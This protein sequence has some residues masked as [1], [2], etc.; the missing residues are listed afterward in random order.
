MLTEL[1]KRFVIELA[2]IYDKKEA[3][4]L[5]YTLLSYLKK[6]SV[7]A[8]MAEREIRFE[9]EE[10]ETFNKWIFRLKQGEPYQYILGETE[11]L[12]RLFTVNSHVLIPRPET[13]E[14][15]LWII[16]E[17][18]QLPSV[19]I[20]DIGTGSGCLAISLALEMPFARVYAMDISESALQVAK[21][22]AERLKAN[23]SFFKGDI[24][25]PVE[26]FPD[27]PWDVI[28]SNPPYIPENQKH[29]IM[30]RVK[31]FEP[32]LALFVPEN[33]PLMFYKAIAD[34]GL[35][36]LNT[37]GKILVEI[38]HEYADVTEMLFKEKGFRNIVIKKDVF[39]K[40]RMI[41]AQRPAS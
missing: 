25:N 3:V 34:Y 14:L 36:S 39:G 2:P 15:A 8:L 40:N 41:Q 5:F 28:V 1:R 35:Q 13:Q 4:H 27:K 33:E 12:S 9:N 38:F 26:T 24:L 37:E 29:E 10:L 6:I 16:D 23:V 18:A 7:T 30:N 32:A 17:Y 20:L 11:F 21:E 19:T 31:D 22:N